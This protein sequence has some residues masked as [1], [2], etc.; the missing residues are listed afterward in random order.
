MG[1]N[2]L[3]FTNYSGFD[4]EVSAGSDLTNYAMD[5]YNYPN[6]RTVTFSLELTF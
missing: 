1:R 3:T 6:F 2:V 5:I 4:P